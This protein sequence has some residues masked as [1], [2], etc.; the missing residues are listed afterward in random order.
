VSESGCRKREQQPALEALWALDAV[1]TY[2]DNPS[3]VEALVS[4]S[5]KKGVTRDKDPFPIPFPPCS[6]LTID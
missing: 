4:Q 1:E 5:D 3:L 6:N 2:P